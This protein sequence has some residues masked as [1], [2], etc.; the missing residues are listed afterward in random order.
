MEFEM[1]RVDQVGWHCGLFLLGDVYEKL[2]GDVTEKIEGWVR[3]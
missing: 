3:S 2:A 1:T